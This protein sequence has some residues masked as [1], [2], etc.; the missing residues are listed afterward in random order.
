MKKVFLWFRYEQSSSDQG[1]L[2]EVKRRLAG[3]VLL[4]FALTL[5][6]NG[7]EIDLGPGVAGAIKDHLER[8][9]HSGLA[10]IHSTKYFVPLDN[11]LQRM[12]ETLA[13][14]RASQGQH[15][16]DAIR[17]VVGIALLSPNPL[18]HGRQPIASSNRI[19]QCHDS[20]TNLCC[21]PAPTQPG[22]SLLV[23]AA[24]SISQD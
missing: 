5:L 8:C 7:G 16:L 18:L 19:L 24:T 20:L 6:T 13:I 23:C 12:L 2:M 21:P 3:E 17:L 14:Q 11:L 1:I 15:K 10:V 9:G 22:S 4:Y